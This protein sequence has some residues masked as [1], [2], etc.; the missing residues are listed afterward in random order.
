MPVVSRP[1]IWQRLITRTAFSAS[2]RATRM[3]VVRRAA[4]PKHS[5]AVLSRAEQLPSYLLIGSMREWK[6]F[7]CRI[8][9]V[10]ART[11]ATRN[12]AVT[13]NRMLVRFMESSP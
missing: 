3:A 7:V 6:S 8:V 13:A 11:L 10:S 4:P 9:N 1:L 12:N 2:A 5:P